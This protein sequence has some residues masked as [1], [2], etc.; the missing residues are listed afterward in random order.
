MPIDRTT[1]PPVGPDPAFA[2]PP[3]ARYTLDSGLQVCVVEEQRMPIVSFALVVAGGSGV[4]PRGLDG[5][6]GIVA[7]MLDEGSGAR[8]AI[9]ISEELA[10]IGAEYEVEVGPDA[11]TASLTTLTKFADRGAR[12]LADMTVRPA[13]RQADFDRVRQLR[14]DRLRQMKDVP[15]AVAERAFLKLLYGDHPYAHLAIGDE[16]SLGSI[17][18]EDV[19]I[20]HRA[21][22]APS[23][24]T[25]V[26]AGGLAAADLLALARDAFGGWTSSSNGVARVPAADVPMLGDGRTRL[27]LVPREGAAQSELR[28]GR[29]VAPRLTPDYPALVVMNAVLGGQ[30]VS[31]INLKLREEK[32]YTYGA[33]TGFDWKKGISP[34][35]LHAS[36]H[37]AS[38]A[39]AIA[40][41]LA[42]FSDLRGPRPVTASELELAKA[43]LTRGY[44][45]HFQTVP[46]LARAVGQLSLFE[47][48]ENYFS[49]FIPLMNAV[50]VDDVSRVACAHLDPET[51][52]TL[53]VGDEA[54]VREPLSRLGLP[55]LE[56]MSPDD[57]Q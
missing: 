21:A 37:T 40:D 3:V 33:R 20:A 42:E 55:P 27:V 47:L 31:R 46:Q 13:L 32:A 1:L 54:V 18:L 41:S 8:G 53:V 51:C 35:A 43:S 29:L 34:L 30:F 24:A 38:T 15:G 44:P 17:A 10:S 5:L 25:M 48:P 19:V 45:Q 16:E 7:D 14:R 26:V 39:N 36:V 50:T 11:T 52:I 49:T 28:I 57:T 22:F 6:A 4:D 23:R 56:V 12:L 9:E 2:F